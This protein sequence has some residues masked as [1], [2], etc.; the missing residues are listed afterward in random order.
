MSTENL[1]TRTRIL[2]AAWK[3]LEDSASKA[4]MSDIAKAAGVS[5]QALY[6]HFPNRADLLIATTRHIDEAKQIE[7]RLAPS[8]AA[9]SGVERLARFIEAW[10][11]YIPEIY[12]VARALMA[13]QDS[14]AEARQAWSDRM[15]A[16]R[17]GCKA[18]VAAIEADGLLAESLDSGT[19]TDLL[20][21]MLSVRNWELLTVQC[22][23]TQDTY[24][25]EIKALAGR[26]LVSEFTPDH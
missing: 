26:S 5:R 22:G 9:T 12:G 6:L 20:W 17:E 23:W 24:I 3:L 10:G 7:V 13:M 25:S 11:N 4:R 14:D 2:N 8:R 19:A 15:L 18:A 1:S 21:A 16:V